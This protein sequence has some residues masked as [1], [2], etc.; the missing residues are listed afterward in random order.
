MPSQ[1]HLIDWTPWP[2]CCQRD[3]VDNDLNSTVTDGFSPRGLYYDV[4]AN[5]F[6]IIFCSLLTLISSMSF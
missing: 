5:V 3:V 4:S 2:R 1:A 6:H